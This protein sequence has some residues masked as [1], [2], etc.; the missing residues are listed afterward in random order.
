MKHDSI[1]IG[2]P[3]ANHPCQDYCKDIEDFIALSDGCSSCEDSDIGARL[4]VK[5]ALH[6]GTYYILNDKGS[7]VTEMVERAANNCHHL[8]YYDNVASGTLLTT[9]VDSLV[10]HTWMFGDGVVVARER[11]SKT[12]TVW[13]VEFPSGAPYYPIYSIHDKSKEQYKE[14]YGDTCIIRA[15]NIESDGKYEKEIEYEKPIIGSFPIYRVAQLNDYDFIALMSDGIKSFRQTISTE[16][17]KTTQPV[18]MCKI[19]PEL[20][21]FK[22]TGKD[23]LKRRV[24]SAIEKNSTKKKFSTMM[25]YL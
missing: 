11:R 24:Y 16:T 23:F 20:L 12:L 10:F 15:Y 4:L 7:M 8:G 3:K 17:S 25:I 2:S 9:K 1:F 6:F 19:I 5:A 22:T 21:S 13:E 14:E 18:D